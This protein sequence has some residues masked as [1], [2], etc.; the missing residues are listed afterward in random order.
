MPDIRDATP[1]D[2]R[3]VYDLLAAQGRAAF[4]VP[5]VSRENVEADFRR[6]V[7]VDRWLAE[8]SG[9][10]VGYAH[11]T[12]AH[13]LVVAS[14]EPVLA[15]ALLARA[16]TRAR[17]RGFGDLEATVVPDDRP[18]HELV[19][20]NR[21]VHERDILRMWRALDGP[22]PEPAW[23]AG[24]TVRSYEG[25]DSCPVHALLDA[26][27]TAWDD[28]YVPRTH[29]DWLSFMT[30]HDEFDPALWFLAE[31]DGALVACALHWREHQR[32]GWV[33][34]LVVRD[35]ERGRGIAKALLHHGFRA[36]AERGVERV[37]L[38][39]DSTNPTGAVQLYERAGF[40]VDRRYGVWRKRL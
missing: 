8:E 28:E 19:R 23:P 21:F 22:L 12:S 6:L 15:D 13:E 20:R 32:R 34:D 3:G 24:V 36:Y 35:D 26:C 40:A 14:A 16:D 11:I 4:G 7:G 5:E 10:A 1:A 29:D 17:A 2:A 9:R 31:R 18:F 39:V 38:K 37:G 27:Y 30:D 33:K 25:A